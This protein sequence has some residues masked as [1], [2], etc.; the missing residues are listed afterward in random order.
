MIVLADLRALLRLD[1]LSKLAVVAFVVALGGPAVAD[2]VPAPDVS[3]TVAPKP[4]ARRNALYIDL[5]GKGGA[6]G[7]GYD[8]RA[9][10]WLTLGAV[11]S[12]YQLHGDS[13]MSLSPYV[14]L[15][16][17]TRGRHSWFAQVGPQILRHSAASPGPEWKG[18]STS[19][20]GGEVSSGYEYRRSIVF[21]VYG[22]ASVGD[23]V[24]PWFGASIGWTW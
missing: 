21:R 23:R 17:V 10:P 14:G 11:G 20:F 6:W 9:K 12:Y 7:L 24:A 15:Y 3:A 16:P 18:M 2:P 19:G 4:A 13:Y 5:L 22:M 1:G 8:W